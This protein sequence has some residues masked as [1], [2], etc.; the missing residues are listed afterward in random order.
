[1]ELLHVDVIS[2]NRALDPAPPWISAETGWRVWTYREMLLGE[3]VEEI[4]EDIEIVKRED[5]YYAYSR[6]NQAAGVSILM[7]VSEST[8]VI[9]KA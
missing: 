1:L 8:L 5:G 3:T 6:G 2:V 9:S 4:L 7:A